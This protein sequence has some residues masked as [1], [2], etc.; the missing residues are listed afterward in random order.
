MK[1]QLCFS[2]KVRSGA[3]TPV[4]VAC[5]PLCVNDDEIAVGC[6][7][8]RATAIANHI[9]QSVIN[10]LESQIAECGGRRENNAQ[11]AQPETGQE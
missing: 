11:Q 3:R 6:R 10:Y 2:V 9:G 4:Y 7:R 8:F 1:N 5:D